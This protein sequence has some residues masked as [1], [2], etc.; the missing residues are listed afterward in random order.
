MN[1]HK[2]TSNK[3][4]PACTKHSNSM[5]MGGTNN[6]V[7]DVSLSSA[8]TNSETLKKDRL[9]D[10][11]ERYA[12][13]FTMHA[14]NHIQDGNSIEKLV[15]VV[16]LVGLFAAAVFICRGIFTSYFRREVNTTFKTTMVTQLNF[17]KVYLCLSD[18][19]QVESKSLNNCADKT[20]KSY[21]P[22]C[23]NLR[24]DK[25]P[26]FAPNPLSFGRTDKKNPTPHRPANQGN[27]IVFNPDGTESQSLLYDKRYLVS[28]THQK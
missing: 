25:F 12:S 26:P 17:P 16:K 23:E 14:L 18:P 11:R 7:M 4:H 13:S 10:I 19:S 20:S 28:I 6:K 15:W 3:L 8:D 9:R 27:C 22:W 24:D 21:M 1:M 2:N 5:K